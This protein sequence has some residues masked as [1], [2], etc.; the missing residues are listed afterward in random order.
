MRR[1]LVAR[2]KEVDEVRARLAL[3]CL[4]IRRIGRRAH[5]LVEALRL[6]RVLAARRVENV[7]DALRRRTRAESATNAE[8]DVLGLMPEIAPEPKRRRLSPRQHALVSEAPLRQQ[9]AAVGYDVAG[10]PKIEVA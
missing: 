1:G 3:E 10:D 6:L 2:H 5:D 4:A 7:R 8:K 9:G